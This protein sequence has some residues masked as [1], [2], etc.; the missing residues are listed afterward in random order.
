MIMNWT[1]KI[2]PSLVLLGVLVF[3][4]A[5]S[6]PTNAANCDPS[7]SGLVSW[8]PAEGNA[9]DII[10]GSNGVVEPGVTFTAGMVGQCFSFDGVPGACVLN[11][12]TPSLTSIQN[13]FTMEFWAYPKAGIV[14]VPLNGPLANHGQQFAIFPDYGGL[15]AQAGAGVSVGT[16]GISVIESAPYY[17]PSLLNYTNFL[18]GWVH[19]AVVYVNKQPTL[20]VNGVNVATGI[21]STRTFV[22]PSKDF[23]G[24]TASPY[25][26]YGPYYGL[27]DEVSIY[28]RALI[29]AEI[30]AIYSAGSSGKCFAQSPPLITVQPVSQTNWV[31]T[32]VVFSVSASSTVPLSYQWFYGTNALNQQTNSTLILTNVQ[33]GQSGSYSVLVSN[34]AGSTNSN[35]AMLIV[36]PAPPCDAPSGMISWWPGEGNTADIIGGSNGVIN[37]GVTFTAGIVGQCF[38]FDGASGCILNDNTPSLT[39][40]QNSFTIEFWAHPQKG[41]RML[42]EGTGLAN[43]GQSYAVFPDFGGSD[44]KAG[45]GVSVG[46]NGISVVEH[47]YNYL[48]SVLSYTNLLNGWI[49]VAVVYANKQP[50]LYVNGVNVRKGVTSTRT[51]VYPSKDFG[52]STVSPW[53]TY[54]AYAGLLDE[55]S[56]Y[57][58]ALTSD[59]I[60]AIFSAGSEGKCSAVILPK[61]AIGATT[62]TN[63]FVIGVNLTDGGYGYTNTPLVRFIGGGGSGA[64]GFAIVS[65]GVVTSITIT[66]AGYGY[67]NA[68]V[69]VLDPPFIFNPFL[70]IA[71]MSFLTFSNLTVGGIYQLQRFQAWYWTNLPVNFTATNAFYTQMVAGVVGSGDYRLALNPVPAQ[72]FATPQVVNGFFVGATVTSGGSGYVT[73]PAVSIVGGGGTNATAISYISGSVVTGIS[74]VNPGTGYTNSPTVRIAPPPAAA[75]FPAVLPVMRVD[76]ASLVPYANNYQ[77][78]FMPNLGGSWVNWD[79]GLFVPTDATNSQFLFITNDIGFFRLQYGP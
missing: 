78:Q 63:G 76:S 49:H 65:N 53:N 48:P 4:F 11:H 39:N 28:N 6:S 67:T 62:A 18:N 3:N 14:M 72:A 60:L 32:L 56:I 36:N 58:R 43:F 51:F 21:A 26:S 54:G 34:G 2:H 70:G 50:T 9:T 73:S 33:S 25:N 47:A 57:N 31:G 13:S 41:F 52:S 22:Y 17:L 12:S 23:G 27:L 5:N 20:Y 7:P 45:V 19:V 59:E 35:P 55:I 15:N 46:T 10:G 40:I 79:G 68:P 61:T 37:S 74:A 42:A 77:I 69:V 44:G 24:F 75:V 30:A 29:P 71:P 16:N 38:S 64:A 66:N 1:F 8:W